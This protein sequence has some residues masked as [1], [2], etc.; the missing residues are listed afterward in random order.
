MLGLLRIAG[1]L[2]F[3]CC[4]NIYSYYADA[5]SARRMSIEDIIELFVLVEYY[6]MDGLMHLCM[7]SF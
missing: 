7:G 2:S 1:G 4:W 6:Q 5:L 3:C